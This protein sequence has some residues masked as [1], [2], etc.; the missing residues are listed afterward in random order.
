MEQLLEL[1]KQLLLFFNGFH[2][3][4]WDN[5]FY[6]FSGKII[7]LPIAILISGVIIKTKRKESFWILLFLITAIV[8]SDQISTLIKTL[9]ERP[10]PTREITLQGLVQTVNGYLAGRYGFVS[11]HASNSFAFALFSVLLFRHR[12]YT[13][14]IFVWA[15][16]NSYSRMYLG[17]HYPGDI[18]GG[19]ILGLS[20][21]GL[22]FY[23]MKRFRPQTLI[24]QQSIHY[25][26]T[27]FS[28]ISMYG[29]MAGILL[30]ILAICLTSF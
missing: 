10:R 22:M 5:F 3:P 21:G 26:K 25:T 29:I 18:L 7:W 16:I 12:I 1:D 28:F 14:T 2:T 13:C 24:Q 11:S 9:V 23:V 30:T 4:F 6:T 19:I 27:G 17:V 20:L 15:T 8:L